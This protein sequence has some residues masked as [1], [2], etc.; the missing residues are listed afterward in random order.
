MVNKRKISVVIP[1]DQ[2]NL[3]REQISAVAL[4]VLCRLKEANYDAYL[5]G[6]CVRDLL[7]GIVPKDFDVVT[8][9]SPWEVKHIF[10]RSRIIGRRFKLV[11]IR[12]GSEVIDVATFRGPLEDDAH[13][14]DHGL[15][16]RNNVFGALEQDVWC[17]DFTIN[18]LYCDGSD[19]SIIDHTGGV[20]DLKSGKIRIIGDAARR[21]REDPVRILR[22]IRF[23]GK[24]GLCL[25]SE[26]ERLIYELAHLLTNIPPARLFDEVLKLYLSGKAAVTHDLLNYYGV[27][28]Y[29]FPQTADTLKIKQDD[30]AKTLLTKALQNTDKRIEKAKPVTPAFILAAL[31]WAPV[32]RR[33]QLYMTDNPRMLALKQAADDVI[34]KQASRV[35]MPRRFTLVA[36]DIWLLQAKMDRR[37]S[38][39]AFALLAHPTFRAAY[40]FLL[41]RSEA[42]EPLNELVDWWTKFQCANIKTQQAMIVKLKPAQ[43]LKARQKTAS[44]ALI[45]EGVFI[46]LGSNLADPVNQIKSAVNTLMALPAITVIHCSSLYISPPMGPKDQPDYINAVIEI[47]TLLSP[48]A[49]LD[50]LKAIEQQHGRLYKR[51]WGERTLDLDLLLYG[52]KVIVDKKLSVPHYGIPARS[53]VL[54]PLAEIAPELVIPKMGSVKRLLAH[55]PADN[56]Q[57][58]E[59]VIL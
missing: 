15:I 17:R 9:A 12:Y 25:E 58:L 7:L 4:D 51:H 52:L 44:K 35:A 39:R 59:D 27:F 16:M 5:V 54:Y 22:A 32:K 6:G 8:N 28:K 43:R 53:F 13:I 37:F 2:H 14:D 24:L 31:L 47:S 19:F 38:K 56:L 30:Y 21:Y 3:C 33:W 49:L 18:A 42:G 45:M 23:V 50:K 1:Y 57:R 48:H 10:R 40:D 34:V 55:C 11:H 26:T 41:L 46:G 36:R 20:A 29:L